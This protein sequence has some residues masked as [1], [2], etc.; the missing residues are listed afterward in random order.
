MTTRERESTTPQEVISLDALKDA[1]LEMN[2]WHPNTPLILV[3]SK[4]R[5]GQGDIVDGGAA[6]VRATYDALFGLDHV[7]IEDAARSHYLHLCHGRAESFPF[8]VR[9][10]T[11]NYGK[12]HQRILKDTFGQQFLT[13]ESEGKYK[14]RSDF[15]K[16]V[17]EY[18]GRSEPIDLRPLVLYFRWSNPGTAK[19]V[20]DL[21]KE[22]ATEFGVDHEPYKHVFTCSALGT[23]LPLVPNESVSP[24][25]VKQ[26]L[27]PSEYGSGTFG[28]EFWTRFRVLLSGRLK[29]LRW[30]G[31]ISGLSAEISAA[32]MH[33]HSLF[34][35]GAPGTGKTTIVLEAVLPALRA[36]CGTETDLRFGYHTLTP[37]TTSSDLFG[38]QGLDGSWIPGPIVDQAL[39]PYVDSQAE[40]EESDPGGELAI[41]RLLFFDEA[42]RVDIEALLSPMQGALDRLQ[43]RQEPPVLTF[44]QSRYLVPNKVWRIFAGNSP[45][46]DSGRREQSRPFKRRVPLVMPPDP[47][48]AALA[49]DSAFT[50]LCMQLLEKS[51]AHSNPES[52]EPARAL[53]GEYTKNSDRIEDL[54]AVVLGI[55]DLKRVPITVGLVESVLLR[56]ACHR[57][58]GT[59][60]S[61]DA[62]LR[63][64]VLS[65]VAGD[66]AAAE[67]VAKI[68]NERRFPTLGSSMQESVFAVQAEIA[69]ELDA[70][71]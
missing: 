34:L 67:R 16:H 46:A 15:A 43:S 7:G 65:L 10:P 64:T 62:G 11:A 29:T 30:Q 26:L 57:A 35:L 37:S 22:F 3:L 27:L 69:I 49:S 61:L 21:W 13:R 40:E 71:L 20:G 54:R 6:A 32:L 12:T 55:R 8:A 14:L 53:L 2:A 48:D 9:K 66:R 33:D 5:K 51:A 42:N 18:L 59:E 25:A 52:S 28:P 24:L 41:P 4:Q 45:A 1:V 31:D 70:I 60:G 44:G 58:L 23:V 17:L 63:A 68:A 36:S 50:R 47:L 19:T 39:V 56:A 38:F